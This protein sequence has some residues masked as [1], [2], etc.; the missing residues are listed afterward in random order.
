MFSMSAILFLLIHVVIHV[1]I[2]NTINI[3]NPIL[4]I[5]V[6]WFY[7][8]VLISSLCFSLMIYM[9]SHRGDWSGPGTLIS[10]LLPIYLVTNTIMNIIRLIIQIII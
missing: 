8:M 4:E 3:E 9:Y 5:V 6:E 10:I 1:V 7:S 2:K